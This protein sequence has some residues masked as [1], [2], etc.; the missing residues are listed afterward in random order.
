ME[1]LRGASLSKYLIEKYTK[2]PKGWNFTIGPAIKDSFFD[3]LVTGPEESW[4]LKIDSIFKPNP[5]MLGAQVEG[6]VSKATAV[7]P[8]YGYRKLDPEIL[9]NIL[10]EQD[11]SDSIESSN[12]LDK[13]IA[14]VEPTAPVP[15]A[16]YAQ[17]P[18]VF[19]NRKILGVSENQKKLDERLNSELRN[20]LREKYLSYG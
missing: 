15:G 1:I 18:F 19:T 7:F 13:L 10:Q 11:G 6:S 3:A 14:S 2:N 17:G 8:D 12:S 5:A 9:L 16:S 20:L 4:Q